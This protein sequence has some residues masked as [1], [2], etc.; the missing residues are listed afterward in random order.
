MIFPFV[1][2]KNKL[3]LLS[4]FVIAMVCYIKGVKEYFYLIPTNFIGVVLYT[5][6]QLSYIIFNVIC[7]QNAFGH[8]TVWNDFF[9]DVD[10]FDRRMMLTRAFSDQVVYKYYSIFI[11][12]NIIYIVMYVAFVTGLK[13]SINISNIMSI[14]YYSV[15]NVHIILTILCFK[16][17][18]SILENRF[19][20]FERN[21]RK[22]Y[23]FIG[24]NKK[25]WNGQQL[26]A[27][28]L[29]LINMVE[30]TNKLFGKRILI[31][32]ISIFLDVLGGVYY[33]FCDNENRPNAIISLAH[34]LVALVSRICMLLISYFFI[35]LNLT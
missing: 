34:S 16:K 13:V 24:P 17:L 23:L 35:S 3:F 5:F 15:V 7:L 25:N 10:E 30:K 19:E 4:S 18:C 12:S 1:G 8:E 21:L 14:S 28:H 32:M 33:V 20:Y 22:T 6:C 31:I 26:K 27:A 2:K 11:I 29:L 9:T